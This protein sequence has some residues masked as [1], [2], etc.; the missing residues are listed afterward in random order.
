MTQSANQAE[1]IL[2]L[3]LDNR[4]I[5][6]YTA[7]ATP[8]A[9]DVIEKRA[10]ILPEGVTMKDISRFKEEKTIAGEF[11]IRF[12]KKGYVQP[13]VLHLAKKDRYCTLIFEPFLS[14][15]RLYDDYR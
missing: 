8:E 5:Y 14:R 9:I 6:A 12:F 13:T 1:Y 3:D 2:H 10:Y 11:D 4:R 15:I 7:D